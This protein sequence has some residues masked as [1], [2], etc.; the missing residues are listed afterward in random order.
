MSFDRWSRDG[1]WICRSP[2]VPPKSNKALEEAGPP[3]SRM[4][5]SLPWFRLGGCAYVDPHT[6][7]EKEALHNL[8]AFHHYCHKQREAEIARARGVRMTNIN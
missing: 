7:R 4:R 5:S 8:W 1:N 2:E 6:S 3:L